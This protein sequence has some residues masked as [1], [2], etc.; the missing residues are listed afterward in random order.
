V[1]LVRWIGWLLG[2]IETAGVVVVA[3]LA[4]IAALYSLVT[5]EPGHA[6]IALALFVAALVY[7]VQAVRR[8]PR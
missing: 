7:L 4:P 5:G 6:V 1:G 3:V 8:R 2:G